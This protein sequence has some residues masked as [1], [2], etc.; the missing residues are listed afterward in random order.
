LVRASNAAA[1]IELK[2]SASNKGKPFIEK[3]TF[4]TKFKIIHVDYISADE[5][6]F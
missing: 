4:D 3:L 1:F 6:G 2:V 5:A